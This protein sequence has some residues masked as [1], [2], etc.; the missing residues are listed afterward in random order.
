MDGGEKRR[1]SIVSGVGIVSLVIWL[2]AMMF[3]DD[4]GY[5]V[6]PEVYLLV[7]IPLTIL[8]VGTILSWQNSDLV[9]ENMGRGII[10][11][12]LGGIGVV[13]SLYVII[14]LKNMGHDVQMYFLLMIIPLVVTMIGLCFLMC[15]TFQMTKVR[16]RRLQEQDLVS[17]SD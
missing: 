4:F 14:S 11:L 5:E 2:L 7:L 10:I 13:A 16:R 15:G 9:G 17:Y 3:L 6:I 12:F 1:A 8:L